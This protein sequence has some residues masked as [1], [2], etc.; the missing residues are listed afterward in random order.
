LASFGILYQEKSGNPWKKREMDTFLEFL[1]IV[2]AQ[3]YV[4]ISLD[5]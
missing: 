3:S 5:Q 4:W 2:G 1:D